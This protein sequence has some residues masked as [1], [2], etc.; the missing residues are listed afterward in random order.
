M[1][2]GD[3]DRNF[4]HFGGSPEGLV[5]FLLYVFFFALLSLS[6]PR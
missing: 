4:L 6:S 1:F 5:R 2:F 3:V